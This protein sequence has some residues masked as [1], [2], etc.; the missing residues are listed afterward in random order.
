MK[1]INLNG[2]NEFKIKRLDDDSSAKVTKIDDK[3]DVNESEEKDE[4]EVEEK[5]RPKFFS[6]SSISIILITFILCGLVFFKYY[7][8]MK[9]AVAL[10]EEER[11]NYATTTTTTEESTESTVETTMTPEQSAIMSKYEER[12]TDNQDDWADED[13]DPDSD[14]KADS[15]EESDQDLKHIY[16]NIENDKNYKSQ[17]LDID[18]ISIDGH[19]ID[20]PASYKYLKD[21]FGEFTFEDQDEDFNENSTVENEIYASVEAK[22]GYG[23]IIFTFSSEGTPKPLNKCNC[24]EIQL[25][26]INTKKD[27]KNM[28]IALPGNVKFGDT[29]EY[30]KENFPYTIEIDESSGSFFMAHCKSAAGPIYYFNGENKGLVTITIKFK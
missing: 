8:D 20:F 27:T 7:R 18:T 30:L 17:L 9:K 16:F 29:Y 5:V 4:K 2:D 19:I 10:Q 13:Y 15:D 14:K 11:H 25:S 12:D 22:T 23:T 3:F 21:I 1:K 28:T 26:S 6:K 24:I